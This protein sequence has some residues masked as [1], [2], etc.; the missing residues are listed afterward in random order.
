MTTSLHVYTPTQHRFSDLA[1]R[2]GFFSID[3]DSDGILRRSE[4]WQLNDGVMSPSLPLAVAFDN[5]NAVVGDRMSSSDDAIFLSNYAELARVSVAD[6]LNPSSDKSPLAGATVFLDRSPELVGAVAKLPSGQ[7]VTASEITAALI[8]D[9]E[10]DRTIISPAWVNA[11][12]WL[13]PVLLAIVAVLFMPER[14]RKDIAVLAGTAIVMLLLLETL[15]LYVLHVRIDLG[16]PILIFFGVAI[17]S[18]WL[19]GDKKQDL[20]DAFKF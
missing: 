16:R 20:K 14:S 15:M 12:E 18:I 6:L 1:S 10:M 8:A 5:P 2:D 3:A 19:V 9:V 17:L 11:L 7:F 4:L 13:A